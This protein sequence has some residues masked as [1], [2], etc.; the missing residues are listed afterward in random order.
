MAKALYSRKAILL[1]R[2][3]A[4]NLIP[5]ITADY[6]KFPEA[7]TYSMYSSDVYFKDPMYDFRGLDQYQKMI[8][9]IT[10]W[11]KNLKLD[12]HEINEAGDGLKTRWTMSWD[13]PLPWKPRIS[14]SGWSELTIS[15]D[16]LI[17]SHIDYWDCSRLDMVKQHLRF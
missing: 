8:G 15:P 7:Q 17:T 14:I 12:L 10:T 6:A 16:N 5:T 11:F 1:N 2:M 9:F 4:Q 3:S 13:A